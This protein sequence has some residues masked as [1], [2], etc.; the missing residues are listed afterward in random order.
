[1]LV[2]PLLFL[3]MINACT[4]SIIIVIY[5]TSL[6]PWFLSRSDILN[7]TDIAG[8]EQPIETEQLVDS[9]HED[10]EQPLVIEHTVGEQSE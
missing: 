3:L 8:I 7:T 4:L 6:P 9:E 10:S 2:I 5:K 1:M